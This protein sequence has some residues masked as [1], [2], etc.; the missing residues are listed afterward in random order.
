M[1]RLALVG[2]PGAGKTTV[3][4]SLARRWGCAAMDTDELLGDAVGQPAGAY[5]RAVGEEIFRARELAALRE[6]LGADAVVST[7]GGVVTSREGR[8]AL[9]AAVTV[10]LDAPDEVLAARLG[11]V[12][13]P[14]LGEDPAATLRE[15]RRQR[16]AWYREVARV[17]VDA[18]GS[19]DE[20]AERVIDAVNQVTA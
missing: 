19:P 13:R 17:R 20:V 12:D 4:Q 14:L 15:L 16:D 7:G 11:D 18:D 10:W 9:L 8:D 1:A 6:A 3:A 5:L 2:L